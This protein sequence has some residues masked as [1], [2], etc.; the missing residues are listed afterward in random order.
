M[1]RNYGYNQS[2]GG[3]GA[4]GA[5]RSKKTKA[6]LSVITKKQMTP[7]A[8]AHLSRVSKKNWQDPDYRKRFE[9]GV[10]KKK[11]TYNLSGLKEFY[12]KNPDANARHATKK[13]CDYNGVKYCSIAE[14]ARQNNMA[15]TTIRRK[16]NIKE[17]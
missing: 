16:V 2:K 9:E 6:K 15:E 5:V 17:T 7:E 1:N 3:S 8:R 10:K 4:Y 14:A 12:K 11:Q 13:P